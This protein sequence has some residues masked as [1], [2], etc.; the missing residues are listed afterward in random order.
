MEQLLQHADILSYFDGI[1]SMEAVQTFKPNPK[2]YAYFVEKTNTDKSNSWLVSGNSF[3]VIGALSYGMNAAWL[4]RNPSTVF[5]P[6][7]FSPN[8][9]IDSLTKLKQAIDKQL[10]A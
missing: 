4:Q 8:L 7:G 9:T 10:E 2:G 5:D 1:V 3:D 6:M